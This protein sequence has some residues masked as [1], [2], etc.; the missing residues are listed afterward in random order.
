MRIIKEGV[1]PETIEHPGT[2]R[3][4]KTEFMFTKNE[5]KYHSD[6]SCRGEDYYSIT[7]PFCHKE[8]YVYPK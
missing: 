6:P 4:C 3:N 8:C 7:C 2:C 5:T 1:L